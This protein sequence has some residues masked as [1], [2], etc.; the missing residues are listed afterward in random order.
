M[1]LFNII[2]RYFDGDWISDWYPLFRTDGLISENFISSLVEESGGYQFA[3]GA[4]NI[5]PN[6]VLLFT[7]NFS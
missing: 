2:K 6:R 1:K 4:L 5:T 3:I 7:E